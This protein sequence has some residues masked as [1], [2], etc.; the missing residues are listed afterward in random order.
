MKTS[1]RN[2]TLFAGIG[3]TAL[4]YSCGNNEHEMKDSDSMEHHDKEG[5]EHVYACPMHPE[6]TGKEGEKCPKCGMALEHNDNAGNTNVY[7]MQF[8]SAPATIESGKE[9]SL[10]FTPK[11]KG[12]DTEQVP[13]DA[14][15]EKKIH[16]IMVSKD[17]SWFD[18][19]HPEIQADGSYIVKTT[20]PAGG[21]YTLFADYT[22]S[23]AVHQLEKIAITVSGAPSKETAYTASA[24]TWKKGDLEVSLQP[25]GGKF[26]TGTMLHIEGIIKQKGKTLDASA[27]E[28]Y[29]GAKAHMVVIKSGTYEYLHVHPDVENGN[30]DLHTTFETPGVYRGWLQFQIN[31]QLH[32]ADFVIN[33]EQGTANA[34]TGHGE[35]DHGDEHHH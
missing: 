28:N 13:L 21:Q 19:I 18:H 31:G 10:N 5:H 1:I 6:V 30:L 35:H 14:V 29:L 24:T 2:L 11:I 16:L 33:V 26:V 4:L 22:P 20:F 9:V 27:F 23:G 8:S 17:L 25:E 12:K 34:T 15:H 3:A 32:T 7:V